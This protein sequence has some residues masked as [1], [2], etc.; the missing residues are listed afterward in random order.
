M[1]LYCISLNLYLQ[2]M[3]YGL[4]EKKRLSKELLFLGF[5]PILEEDLVSI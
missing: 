5:G 3:L 1:I 4:L 2:E